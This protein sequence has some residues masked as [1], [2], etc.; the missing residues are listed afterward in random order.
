MCWA[1]G[2]YVRLAALAAAISM[3]AVVIYRIGSIDRF[4]ISQTEAIVSGVDGM[5]YR[6]H[7]NH[8]GPQAAADTLAAINKN[9][10]L[11]LRHLRMKYVRGAAGDASPA[12][13]HA[14]E[15]ILT[16]YNPD[17]LAENSPRDPDGDTSYSLD[18]GAVVALC[19][20]SRG[21]GEQIHDRETLMFVTIHELAH[22]SVDQLQHPPAYWR[23]FKFLLEEAEDAGV[24]RSPDYALTPRMYCGIPV[25]YNPRYDSTLQSL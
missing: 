17:N 5:S 7:P 11:L 25:D 6:V 9:V 23:A 1:A 24:Y 4:T 22:L 8:A 15:R 13:R 18:K 19:L 12:R 3:L 2:R 16:R 14:A 10:V 20:R 21:P